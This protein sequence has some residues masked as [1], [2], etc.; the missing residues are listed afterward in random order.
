MDLHFLLDRQAGV[1]TTAQAVTAGVSARTVR[2]RR[3]SGEWEVLHPGVHL[4]RGHRLTAEARIRAAWLWAGGERAT[5]TGPAAAHWHRMLDRAPRDVEITVPRATHLR[6]R[7]GIALRRRDLTDRDRV[8]QD[9]LWVADKPLAALA[10]TL[11]A[12]SV[13]LDRALQR[14]VTLAALRRTHHRHLGEHGS[15]ELGRL[16]A[17]AA[18]GGESAAERLLVRLLREAGVTGWV[19]GHPFGPY[20]ID[21]AFPAQRVAVEVD[22]WAFHSDVA[23]FQADRRKGNA[24]TRDRWDLLRYTWHDLDGRPAECV[25]E[26]VETVL[27]GVV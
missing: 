27:A 26:I 1:I 22:G 21:V 20:R 17:A 6:S 23:R 18:D 5:V 9:R 25:R 7:P 16:P 4:V 10:T 24:I 12:G 13:F 8:E 2:R 15:P 11:T 19:L 3:R 14:H